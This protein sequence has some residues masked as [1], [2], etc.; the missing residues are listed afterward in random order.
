[1]QDN[2]L[3]AEG[4]LRE[5]KRQHERQM[6]QL[7]AETAAASKTAQKESERMQKE[8]EKKDKENETLK[9]EK[10]ILEKARMANQPKQQQISVPAVTR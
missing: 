5:D 9:K 3:A 8:M 4:R 2:T 7:R 10:A 1:M 6:Q